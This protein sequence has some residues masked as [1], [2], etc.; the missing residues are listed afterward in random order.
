MDDSEYDCNRNS[1]PVSATLW[2]VGYKVKIRG[3]GE[4]EILA[5]Y[6]PY[7]IKYKSGRKEGIAATSLLGEP[8]SAEDAAAFNASRPQQRP[9]KNSP[10]PRQGSLF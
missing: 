10:D 4:C 5:H 3:A 7:S 8:P 6:S 9:A 2:P 1:K